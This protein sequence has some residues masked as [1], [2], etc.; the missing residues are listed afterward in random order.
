MVS[1]SGLDDAEVKRVCQEVVDTGQFVPAVELLNR[2]GRDWARRA[3]A[4]TALG[5]VAAKSPAWLLW[6][7]RSEP[8]SPDQRTVMAAA[9]VRVAWN[10]RGSAKASL[11]SRGQF[12]DFHQLL[13]DADQ[14]CLIA[15]ESAPD[16]PTPW[17]SW[18][19]VCR[20]LPVSRQVFVARWRALRER[21]P[22][23]RAGHDAALQYLCEKWRG[24]HTDMYAFAREAAEYAPPGSPLTL[25]VVEAHAEY[26][27]RMR[28]NGAGHDGGFW[29]EPAQQ[30]DLDAALDRYP[31]DAPRRYA[32]HLSDHSVLTY[33]LAKAGRWAELAD[34]FEATDHH[35]YF[36]PWTYEEGGSAFLEYAHSQAMKSRSRHG[37]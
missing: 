23:H 16:D 17:V 28:W 27:L 24:S 2:V 8:E 29:T 7:Q 31:V 15:T 32:S 11:T 20:G 9:M 21:D 18:L 22:L 10:A 3:V 5:E 30:A 6:W 26:G 25:L 12:L 33:A 14:A 35:A 1:D 4:V 19:R 37:R 13:R 34:R 36:L